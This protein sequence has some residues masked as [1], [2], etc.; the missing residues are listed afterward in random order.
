MGPFP[1][2]FKVD[3]R[4][5]KGPADILPYFENLE[6]LEAYRLHRPTYPHDIIVPVQWTSGRTFPVLED[7]TIVWPHHPET[8]RLYG[9]AGLPA[10]TQFTYDDHLIEPMSDFRLPKLNKLVVR[11]EAWSKPRGGIQLVS[12]WGESSNPKWLRP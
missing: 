10:C 2:H 5:M 4:E 8:L 1:R 7:C 12:V 9:G 11:N 3:V 6:V